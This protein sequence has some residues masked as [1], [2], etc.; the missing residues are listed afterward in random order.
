MANNIY[1]GKPIRYFLIDRLAAG[2]DK[3]TV[4]S[5][6]RSFFEMPDND[7]SILKMVEGAEKE[8]EDRRIEIM[9]EIEEKD[10]TSIVLRHINK[11]D[12]AADGTEDVRELTSIASSLS[13]LVSIVKPKQIQTNIQ[14]TITTNNYNQFNAIFLHDLEKDGIIK[15]TDAQRFQK[16][17]GAS[18]DPQAS[19]TPSPKISETRE[20]GIGELPAFPKFPKKPAAGPDGNDELK[21]EEE[22][23]D[24]DGISAFA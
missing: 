11:L 19:G 23:E 12:Y 3:K 20:I 6:F 9:K 14:K 24:G 16:L 2:Y 10:L 21:D 13:N 8:I 1:R 4:C 5:M 18:L 15:I 17:F 7:E 22:D